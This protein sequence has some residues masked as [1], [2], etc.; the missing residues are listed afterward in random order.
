M[1]SGAPSPATMR[2]DMQILVR[3]G[4]VEQAGQRRGTVYKKTLRGALE[5]PY[6]PAQ[7]CT[8]SESV[9]RA[10]EQYQY[11]YLDMVG[12]HVL[13][14]ETVAM[15]DTAT[16]RYHE[17]RAAASRGVQKRELERFVIEF[18]WKSSAIEGNTYSL[19]DTE[20]L[21]TEGVEAPGH[22]KEEARMI[23][24]H[25]QA[26][27]FAV[28]LAPEDVLTRRSVEDLHTMLTDGLG[29]SRGVRRGDVGIVGTSYRPPSVATR[30][31][32]ELDVLCERVRAMADP[33]SQALLALVGTSYLQP[34]E[35][36]NKRTARL[37]ANALLLQHDRAPISYRDTDVRIYRESMLVFY[38][39]LSLVPM[40]SIFVQQYQYA[41]GHYLA[42]QE[43]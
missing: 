29:V 33:Y 37:L 38:E 43:K 16:R 20:R 31:T 24:N 42:P 41:C 35:D 13:S 39:Q 23:L 34:F 25:K 11:G 22:S 26:L 36:G 6:E 4:Y 14:S 5:T 32:E 3:L 12:D 40:R 2:R 21:L 10:L 27:S 17:R 9:R 30:I 1:Q 28:S 18:S 15:L 19:L 8:Q 7:Y